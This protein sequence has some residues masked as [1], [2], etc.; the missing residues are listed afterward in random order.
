MQLEGVGEVGF[1]RRHTPDARDARFPMRLM[2]DPMRAEFFPRGIPD[3]TRHYWSGPILNQGSTGTCVAHG[4]ASKI[5]AAPIMQQLTVS[6]FDLYRQIVRVDEWPDNDHEATAPDSQLQSGTSVRAAMKTMTT[7]GY[8][9]AY[10]WAEGAEDV[11]AWMLGGFGG[12]VL[13][14]WWKSDMMQADREGF[15]HYT[16][17]K[18]GGHCVYLSGWNDRVPHRGG[19]VRAVRGQQSWGDSWGQKGRFW[20][21]MDDLDA[22]IKDD[23]EAAALTE[24]RVTARKIDG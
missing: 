15:I 4:T 16:G 20:M 8:A 18:E 10:L 13:G 19:F 7:L 1:G 2:L 21:P 12:V 14:I 11:R 17:N 9:K 6:V 3:G 23:G 22:A 5:H 24:N